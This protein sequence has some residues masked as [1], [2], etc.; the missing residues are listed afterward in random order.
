MSGIRAMTMSRH[1]FRILV[2]TRNI[3]AKV[4]IICQYTKNFG[5]KT[6]TPLCILFYSS[7]SFIFACKDSANIWIMQENYIF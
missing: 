6:S 1:P 4:G 2:F 3:G 7:F 5:E